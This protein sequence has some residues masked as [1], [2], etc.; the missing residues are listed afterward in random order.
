[1][2]LVLLLV[3]KRRNQGLLH[4]LMDVQEL[5]KISVVNAVNYR[6]RKK[7]LQALKPKLAVIENRIKN[8]KNVTADIISTETSTGDIV[9]DATKMFNLLDTDGNGTLSYHE[10]NKA[11]Q[12]KPAALREFAN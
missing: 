5:S 2:A 7:Q 9:F 8:V 3:F 6:S 10:L 1:M 11:L 12:L 4:Q